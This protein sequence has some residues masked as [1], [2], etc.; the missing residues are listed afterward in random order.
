MAAYTPL[1]RVQ[2]T[3][4]RKYDVVLVFAYKVSPFVKWG[5]E[6]DADNSHLRAPTEAEAATMQR[7]ETQRKTVLRALEIAGL[8]VMA[9]YSRD[10]DEIFV[11]VGAS[12]AKLEEIA[13][14]TKYTLELKEEYECAHA[15]FRRDFLG[16]APVYDDRKLVSHLYKIHENGS[17]FRTVDRIHLTKH[18]I[19]SPE[20]GCAAVPVGELMRG[21]KDATIK[22]YFPL[23]EVTTLDAFKERWKTYFAWGSGIDEVRGYFGE[24]V[25]YYWLWMSFNLKALVPLACVGMFCFVWD[26]LIGTPNNFTAYSFCVFVGV[27]STLLIHGWRRLSAA[28]ALQW[29]TLEQQEDMLPPRYMFYGEKRLNPINDKAELYYPWRSRVPKYATSY[30]IVTVCLAG[31]LYLTLCLFTLRHIIHRRYDSPNAPLVFQFVNA[32]I[33]EAFNFGFGELVQ[34]LN[35][36]ENHRT[37]P[38]HERNRLAK[39][40]VFKLFNSFVSLY[41]IA[42]FKGHDTILGEKLRC[43]HNDCLLD[44]SSQLLCFV[45]VRLVLGN[46][47]EWLYPKFMIWWR[48]CQED[49]EMKEL[50]KGSSVMLFTGMS[51]TEQQSKKETLDNYEEM[52]EMLLTHAYTTMFVVACPWVPFVSLGGIFLECF[53]DSRK[54]CTLYKRPWPLK[55]RNNE[56]WDSA[57]DIVGVL[58]ML[59]NCATVVWATDAYASYSSVDK[60]VAF[61]MLENAILAVRLVVAA[62]FPAPATSILHLQAKQNGLVS[63]HLDCIQTSMEPTRFEP[64]GAKVMIFDRDED[65]DE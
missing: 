33:V 45:V 36:N 41:Y 29:G 11:K 64:K 46:L 21:G 63:K 14:T 30:S 20:K 34:R 16:T 25:A 44:L 40:M 65:D 12:Q 23:H 56:P 5:T 52:E 18:M 42:F 2:E 61:F 39:S 60:V 6:T 48:G 22:H 62:I 32:I 13:E 1:V 10:R 37:E 59:T 24:A 15:E 35:D 31:L 4:V 51:G 53:L 57:F 8:T 17:C 28:K 26:V 9:M 58:A 43:R 55:R 38:E 19:Q 49:K 27:W 47:I 3:T 54:T 50:S 7:W